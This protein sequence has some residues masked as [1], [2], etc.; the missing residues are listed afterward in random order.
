VIADL[1]EAGFPIAL[2]WFAPLFEFRFP[3]YGSVT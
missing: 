1:R 3:V 2:A